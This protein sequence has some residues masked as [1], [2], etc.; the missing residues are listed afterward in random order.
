MT[1][2][3]RSRTARRSPPVAGL[4][5]LL[6]AALTS[7]AAAQ[8]PPLPHGEP[9]ASYHGHPVA[10]G[11]RPGGFPFPPGYE[12]VNLLGQTDFDVARKSG[13]CV[14]CHQNV[15]DPHMK[16]T[17][18]LGCIDCHGGDPTA[19]FKELAH[20]RPRFPDAWP[21]SGNPAR[22]YTL[23]NHESPEFIRFVNPGDLRVAHIS[24][25][26]SGCHGEIV[27]YVR[28]SMMT[29]G[30]M[31]WEAA[32]YNNG[33]Y[34][35]KRAR[36][37]ES[38]SMHGVPQRVQTV[39]PPTEYEMKV[40]GVLPFLDPLPRFEVSQPGN[41]LRIF[42]RGRLL[43]A[44]IGFP[45]PVT[46]L[47]LINAG[48]DPPGRP[49]SGLS[50]RGL[51]TKNRT[52]P[53]LIG[54]QKTRLLDPTLNFLGTND[55]AGDFRSSGCTACHVVY[56]NDRSPV[57][58]GPFAVFGNRGTSA[59]PDPT[60]PKNEPGHP[61]AHEFVWA[62]PTSQCMV[63]HI[64]PGTT[65]MNSYVGY[66]WWDLETDGEL[67]YPEEERDPTAEQFVSAMMVDPNE[68]S[69]RGLWSDPEFLSRVAELNAV[70]EKQQFADFHG[71][72]WVFDAVFKKD[73]K[74][75]LLD[76]DGDIVPHVDNAV[77]QAAMAPPSREER[78]TDG[79][80]ADR[81]G[82]PLHLMDIHMEKG[83]HCVD[84]HFLVS[85]HGNGKLYGEVR[86]A[87]EIQCIDCHG[88]AV[89]YATLMTSGPASPDGGLDLKALRTPFG[90]P[91]F[92]V[93][94][95]Q[96]IQNSMVEPDLWW[97]VVQTADTTTPGNRDYNQKSHLAKTVRFEGNN[98]V[99]GDLPG[100]DE[101]LCPHSST[102][103]SCQACHSSWNPSCYGCHLPQRA[104]MKMPELHNGGD[105]SRNYVSYNWQTLRDDTFMIARDGDVTGNR[106]NPSRSSCA[107]HVTSYNAQ[108]EAIYIQQQTIS[109]EGLSGIAF[110]TNVPHT[111]RGGPPVDPT[112][113][114]ALNPANYLPGRGE[115]KQCTDCH[116][117]RA[118][119]NNAI[120]AQLLMHGTNF[121]NFL[122]RY[123]WVAA[124]EHGLFAIEVTERDEPQAVIGSTMHALV[125]PDRYKEHLAEGREL[126]VAHEHPGKDV[127]E[128]LSLKYNKPEV[129]DLQARGEFLYAACGP[130]GL[131]VFDI[132]FID[133]KGFSERI[134]TAPFSPLGQRFYVRTRYA[135]C[136]TAPTTLA[137][138]PTRHHFPENREPSVPL[139]YAFLYVGD[140][141]EGIILVGAASLLDGNPLN[142]FLKRDLT[143]N[144]GGIL[145]GTRKITF[146]GTYAYVCCDAGIVVVD[147]ANPLDPKVV[148][149]IGPDVVQHPTDFQAQFRYGFACDEDGLKVFDIT[150]PTRPT[151]VHEVP[152]HDAHKAFLVRTYAY[153][154]AGEQGLVIVDIERPR[155]AFIDQVYNAEGEIND[156]HDV[157]VA[158]TYNSLFAYLADG[159]NG[160]RVVQLTSPYTSGNDG[161]SP[162][163]TP[164]LVASHKLAEEGHAIAIADTLDRDR[165]VDESG[166]QLSVFGR[167]GARPLNLEEQRRLY[168][169][170]GQLYTV[171]DDPLDFGSPRPRF[172]ANIA[173]PDAADRPR[174]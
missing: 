25:G 121:M 78:Q 61:I 168:L 83:M 7:A 89:R 135:T 102:N 152:I 87:I 66:M 84:C 134:L 149:V 106:I 36:F 1:G 4:V 138:D 156:L 71:H 8:A 37:G 104:N 157:K 159:K 127:G 123:A 100:N 53:V 95:G 126:V 145:C 142:N 97:R 93:K 101:D 14:T 85:A 57:H 72:G 63:C 150:D 12:Q 9:P 70:A 120:M 74:G 169:R 146:Y 154:A 11:P 171:T 122:G 26:T 88:T 165:A 81:D 38:Y 22:S 163:P 167:I 132:A 109:S 69:A 62:P 27:N 48:G 107:I 119:D 52:D 144:P 124:G 162:R 153:V 20:V 151:F 43:P 148:T 82:V 139:P 15:G 35:A 46:N 170:N 33:S 67:L 140:K 56:A 141:Y 114:R 16:D 58:S 55:K 31:L 161:F 54:L 80:K 96:L 118:D 40:E 98:L 125:Y 2:R 18:R 79:S 160:L 60:I 6:G 65:V 112:T 76:A 50:N 75:R 91:R 90:K 92:E 174:R 113:G 115:T 110:S 155:E 47:G 86:N 17:V 30:A 41:V 136:V 130:N 108:R 173:R 116:V 131:R 24:C 45:A 128:N 32:L 94:D 111:V 34:P 129:L 5:A 117:S 42:E 49:V 21:T 147:F 3:D 172:P 137:P 13:T 28:K 158:I 166:N 51:G 23:L 105:V 77:L 164:H 19:E 44:E 103:M 39:P 68:A 64:H 143:F 99:W 10:H 73:R 59:S 29:H 133:N